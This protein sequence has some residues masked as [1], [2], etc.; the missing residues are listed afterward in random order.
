MIFNV[1]GQTLSLLGTAEISG[2]SMV[3]GHQVSGDA[4]IVQK[5]KN[6]ATQ[7]VIYLS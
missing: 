3:C 2:P 5:V 6:A 7:H 4:D 1:P